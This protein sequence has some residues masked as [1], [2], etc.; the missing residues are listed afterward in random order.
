MR[1]C[2]FAPFYLL[3]VPD[4]EVSL[5]L[6]DVALERSVCILLLVFWCGL[7]EDYSTFST[8]YKVTVLNTTVPYAPVYNLNH[9]WKKLNNFSVKEEIN[10]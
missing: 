1:F 7:E 3:P 2:G 10:P 9:V 5:V 8:I 4:Q 6:S